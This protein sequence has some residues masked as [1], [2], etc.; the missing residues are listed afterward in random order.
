MLLTT[1]PLINKK[2]RECDESA[3]PTNTTSI[4]P[5]VADCIVQMLTA[6]EVRHAFGVGGGA[7]APLWAALEQS[8][9]QVLH[10][11][12]EAGAAFAAMEGYF[13]DNSPIVV[14]TTT[15]PGITNALTGILA[16][17]WEGAKVIL[18][19]ASTPTV[20]HGKWALQE[21]SIDTMP[22]GIFTPGV[23][24]HYAKCIKSGDDLPEIAHELAL[25][26]SRPGG[27]VAHISIPT[28]IQTST[29]C[30]LSLPKLN[31]PRL[32][33][34]TKII[35]K[36]VE[37]LSSAPF[38]IWLGFGARD[39]A[40]EILQLAENTGAA[41]MSSPR[42]KG[43]FPEN[44]P[45]FVGVT[46]FAGHQS[47]LE[48]MQSIPPERILV[49][50]TRLG[51]FTSF[52]SPTTVPPNGFIHVDIDPLIPGAAYPT[53][54]TFAICADIKAFLRALLEQ[55][56]QKLSWS[57][58]RTLH[59]THQITL[60]DPLDSYC[61]EC[62]PDKGLVRPKVLMDKIQEVIVEGSDAI[63]LAE[64]GNSFAWAT[65]YLK[66]PQT[67]RWRANTGFG[68]MGHATTGVVGAAFTSGGKAV[69]IVGDGAMLMNN[70]INTAVQYNIPAVWIVLN[71][72][73]YNMCA[74]GLEKLGY[75]DAKTELVLTDFV[76]FARS[77]GADGICVETESQIEAALSKAMNSE[78]PFVVDVKINSAE[79]A[80][81]G[82][83]LTS[84]IRQYG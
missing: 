10:F 2:S 33:P 21:T 48:Y 69:A 7:I 32:L 78:I 19:S 57:P 51:E 20:L 52:W 42:G 80:P 4:Q 66:F 79:P 38:A 23:L 39:A 60:Q 22:K 84:L 70:E 26:L 30:N 45:Q 65:H 27:F 62:Q 61:Q 5:T 75:S 31:S 82:T 59:C 13:A 68:A 18:L 43:I 73:C 6:L 67:K 46:G 55:L 74:Q 28:D 15:G 63:V 37:L 12:H 11:R 36:A 29:D 58:V 8:C 17:R 25:G 41:V 76:M 14:F 44:H 56:P 49:L 47:V 9:I 81:I 53:A 40:E 64:A 34:D 72:A 24:F 71:D 50:G 16:A 54:N 35:T 83:R 3:K 1:N 77:M